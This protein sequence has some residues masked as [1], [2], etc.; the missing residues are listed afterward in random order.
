MVINVNSQASANSLIV[1]D[2]RTGNIEAAMHTCHRLTESP[3]A[4]AAG[5]LVVCTE[6]D[7][8][9]WKAAG[10]EGAADHGDKSQAVR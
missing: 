6:G 8:L 7:V 4:S 2:E 9:C 1:L 5:V 10:E 3:I